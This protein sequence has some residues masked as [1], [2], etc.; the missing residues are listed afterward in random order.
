MP[1]VILIFL[2]LF[3]SKSGES[4]EDPWY[5]EYFDQMREA[6]V[7]S[8]KKMGS[9]VVVT[10]NPK[11]QAQ[12]LKEDLIWMQ[13]GYSDRQMDF[14]VAV[15]LQ[16]GLEKAYTEL[17]KVKDDLEKEKI[18]ERIELFIILGEPEVERI[19]E[20]VLPMKDYELNFYY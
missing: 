10:N 11:I 12:L 4:S 6:T 3:L 16:L 14:I 17:E 2:L 7:E 8:L 20:S 1:V 15:V 5:K 18:K 13:K 19:K 9:E